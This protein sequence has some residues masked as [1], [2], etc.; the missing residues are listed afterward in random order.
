MFLTIKLHLYYF[1]R[2]S[3]TFIK[4]YSRYINEILYNINISS[5]LCPFGRDPKMDATFPLWTVI[6]ILCNKKD[7]ALFSSV[8]FVIL[9]PISLINDKP[10]LPQIP[11]VSMAIGTKRK[12]SIY[13]INLQFKIIGALLWKTYF[14]LLRKFHN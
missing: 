9:D 1:I 13:F 4:Y 2:N 10:S 11:V 5:S 12:L 6:L 3:L 7:V 8:M 14:I